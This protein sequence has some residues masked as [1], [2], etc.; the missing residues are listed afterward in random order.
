MRMRAKCPRWLSL[1]MPALLCALGSVLLTTLPVRADGAWYVGPAGNDAN[2][3]TAPGSPC[4]TIGGA[5]AKASAGDTINVAAGVYYERLTIAKPLIFV[6]AGATTTIVDGS[7]AGR[8]FDFTAATSLQGLTLRNGRLTGVGNN[9]GAIRTNSPLTLTAVTIYTNTADYGGGVAADA[10]VVMSGT[11]FQANAASGHSGALA[12]WGSLVITNSDFL[13]NTAG[14]NTGAVYAHSTASITNG[15]FQGNTAG[16]Y[17]GALWVFGA[18]AEITDSLF[19]G[20]RATISKTGAI[21]VYGALTL[22]ASD[23]INNTAGDYGGAIHATNA[24]T[25]SASLFEGN[26]AGSYGGAI[27]VF[28]ALVITDSDFFS[29]TAGSNSGAVYADTTAIVANSLFQGNTTVDYGGALG[30]FGA[31]V[32]TDSDFFSN[33]AGGNSGAVHANTTTTVANSLFQGNTT[34]GYSGALGVFGALVITDSDFFSNTAGS[35]SG[36]VY[37]DTTAAVA[38]SLFQG[39]TAKTYGGALSGFGRLVIADSTFISN[40]ASTQ[41]SGAVYASTIVTVTSSLFQRNTAKTYG[42]ALGASGSLVITDSTFVSNTAGTYSGAV[43]ANTT[44]TVTSS[45]FQRNTAGSYGGALGVF[46]VLVVTASD[47]LSNM[48]GSDSGA[49][50]ANS[51]AT[52][53]NGLFQD[54]VASGVGGAI[55]VGSSSSLLTLRDSYFVRNRSTGS[56]GGAVYTAGSL[57]ATNTEFLTNTA[58]TRKGAVSVSKAATISDCLF[59]GNSAP[60]Y[61]GAMEVSGALVITN[62]SFISNTTNQYGGAIYMSTANTSIAIENSRFL[63]NT[64]ATSQAGAIYLTAATIPATI[65]NSTFQGNQAATLGGAIS[66]SGTLTVTNSYFIDNQTAGNGGAIYHGGGAARPATIRGG[67]FIGNRAYWGGGVYALAS[68]DVQD[69]RFEDN[70]ARGVDTSNNIRNGGG[71]LFVTGALVVSNTD[72]VANRTLGDGGAISARGTATITGGIFERNLLTASIS[73]GAAIAITGTLFMSGTQ[74]ISN[75][76]D[77]AG[78]AIVAGEEGGSHGNITLINCLF[79]RNVSLHSS[80]GALVTYGNLTATN[81]QFFTN[82]ASTRRGAVGVDENATIDGG[83][84]QGNAAGNYAGALEVGG[85]LVLTASHFLSNT[86]GAEDGAL[87]VAGNATI[88]D[89]RF[90]ANGAGDYAGAVEVGGELVLTASHFLSNTAGMYAG[91]IYASDNSA[92]ISI[93]GSVFQGNRAGDYAGALSARGALVVTNSDFW[94]NRATN[95][96]G[97]LYAARTANISDSSFRENAA[98]DYAGAVE[99]GGVLSMTNTAFIDNSAGTYGGALYTTG[100]AS[101]DAVQFVGNASAGADGA[102]IGAGALYAQGAMTLTGSLFQTNQSLGGYDAGALYGVDAVMTISNTDFLSNTATGS[103]GAIRVAAATNRPELHIAGSLFQANTANVNTGAIDADNILTVR[104]SRFV[105]NRAASGDGGA[106]RFDGRTLDGLDGWGDLRNVL[107]D[108]NAAGGAGAALYVADA[109]PLRVVYTTI[110]SPTVGAGAAIYVVTGTVELTNTIVA[111]Y[112]TGIERTGGAVTSD[113]NLFYHAPTSV[114]AG[115]HS[116]TDAD[117]HFLAPTAGDYHLMVDSPAAGN[118]VAWVDAPTDLDGVIR[119]NPSTLGVFEVDYH[120]LALSKQVTPTANVAYGNVVTYTLALSNS[121]SLTDTAA[122]FTDTLPAGV[123]FGEWIENRNGA[124]VDANQLTWRGVV[125]PSAVLTFSFTATHTGAG[126]TT[127]TNTARFGGLAQAGQAEAVFHSIKVGTRTALTSTQHASAF[128]QS[129]TFTATITVDPPGVGAPIGAVTFTTGASAYTTTLAADGVATVTTASLPVGSHIITATYSS[130]SFVT[131]SDSLTQAVNQADTTTALTS[132]LNASAFGQSVTFTATVTVNAPGAGTPSGVVTFTTASGELGTVNLANGVATVST[133]SLPVGSHVVTATYGGDGSFVTSSDSLTQAVNQADTT[134]ALTSALNASAFGQSVTFTATVT[135]NA[136]G[137]GT[138]SGVVT[139]TTAS[140]ELGTVNLAN[141]VATVTTASLP[142]GSHVVTA[143]YGGDD[144]FAGSLI[145]TTHVVTRSAV[146]VAFT[147][148]PN[149]ATYGEMVRTAITVTAHHILPAARLPV[150]SGV[151]TL[152]AGAA[153]VGTG[154]VVNGVATVE[155]LPPA[156]GVHTLMV[157]YSGDDRHAPG[158]AA[159]V[160]LLVAQA[161]T[162][163][164]LAA[165]PAPTIYGAPA[166]F[167]ITV[168]VAAQ[169]VTGAAPPAPAR[170]TGQVHLQAGDAV[171]GVGVL[172]EGVAVINVGLLAGGI[173]TLTAAYAGDANY[174]ASTAAAIQ[175][176][177]LPAPAQTSLVAAP[178]PAAIH[179]PVIF[180]ATVQ[181]AAFMPDS[182]AAQGSLSTPT[183]EVTFLAGATV[184]GGTALANGMAT[185]TTDALAFGD[186]AITAHYSGDANYQAALSAVLTQSITAP[187]PLAVNDAAGVLEGE[188][189]TIAVLA[190]DINPAGGGLTVVA[191]TQPAHG[192]ASINPDNATVQYAAAAGVGGLD[193]FT[194]TLQDANGQQSTATVAVVVTMLTETDGAPQVAVLDPTVQRTTHFTSSQAT[195]TVDAPAGVYTGTL[196]P[197]QVFFLSYT[198]IVTPTTHTLTPPGTLQ[199]GNFEFELTAFLD[200]QPLHGLVFAQPLVLTIHY[201]PTLLQGIN[202]ATLGLYIWNGSNW[203]NDGI[204]IVSHDISAATL[205]ITLGYLGDFALF[206]AAVPTGL[207]PAPEPSVLPMNIYLPAVMREVSSVITHASGVMCQASDVMDDASCPMGEELAVLPS[208]LYL[209]AVSR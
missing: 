55:N 194:Y 171:L 159:D 203:S 182:L 149:P 84:F 137:A 83:R 136:P 164:T 206:G 69:S 201:A 18:A 82:T 51:T 165:P 146:A 46:G 120:R 37:A 21:E 183:G 24:V 99:A 190:N 122:V 12:V 89:S 53:T 1:A 179:T 118:G 168:Q 64:A 68:V 4:L 193:S 155:W 106:I 110:V 65:S 107:L 102:G 114:A 104:A 208:V 74:V 35:N 207:D 16:G 121:G 90:Q 176:T 85:D 40:T 138:P 172:V 105:Q 92:R 198:P 103:A 180:T 45:L 124:T 167:T 66:M 36:A 101:I 187:A 67:Q 32:V 25:I 113:Y 157:V 75:T 112:T 94:G 129:V 181:A 189:V 61:A 23:F 52:V 188:A 3:C 30:A 54:N 139:F 86:A 142:V 88:S 119:R 117:P 152:S 14:S 196:A 195:V 77:Q 91:A 197:Q 73:S 160:S 93:D 43:Y 57:M 133:A 184:L 20:N 11:L 126:D 15:R 125:T 151:V 56:S 150:P 62:S 209:P 144:S 116:I 26:T 140:G 33:T 134:T 8:I 169:Q 191:V 123:T 166:T 42:G 98:G 58:S 173:H 96:D 154:S 13:S 205:T 131:S 130:S 78:G 22:R 135:V 111:S 156:T 192:A 60:Q 71:G 38:S 109:A 79:E 204:T 39:N 95:E 19:L 44:T 153:P 202:P 163:S 34:A 178:N 47:F 115:S 108:R 2:S 177:V 87:Y 10:S 128:G 6:G 186:H 59:Q 31:L 49:I 72:F 81:T 200:D 28:G 41:N 127:I 185:V 141:G 76:S 170:P 48:A 143:T 199:F 175:H 70:F 161:A 29:N 9:G 63:S 158:A 80:G 162:T 174:L 148:A 132:A 7:G 147:P 27:G 100:A 97:A 17:I 5:V 50:Y 145:T